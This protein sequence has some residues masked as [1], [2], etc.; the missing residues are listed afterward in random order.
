VSQGSRDAAPN[1][2]RGARGV[3]RGGFTDEEW[4][5]WLVLNRRCG[6]IKLAELSESIRQVVRGE[7]QA[8]MKAWA[9]G[10]ANGQ[11]WAHLRHVDHRSL[12]RARPG[13]APPLKVHCVRPPTPLS[14]RKRERRG[15]RLLSIDGLSLLTFGPEE[16]ERP[17]PTKLHHA[18][19]KLGSS[20]A[21]AARNQKQRPNTPRSPRG[22]ERERERERVRESPSARHPL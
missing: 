2:R 22:R 9:L 16:R 10:Q 15:T 14:E 18:S 19:R 6:G 17:A 11:R 1:K 5:K 3:G 13:R 4:L 12:V 20:P 21:T 7:R 8:L